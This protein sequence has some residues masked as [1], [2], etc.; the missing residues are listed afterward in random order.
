MKVRFSFLSTA[1]S[2]SLLL[3]L[4]AACSGATDTPQATA[5]PDPTPGQA[6]DPLSADDRMAVE[7]AGQWEAIVLEWDQLHQD[8]DQWRAG[9]TSCHRSSVHEALQG[10]AADF[11]GVTA[12]AGSL[13]RAT[14]TQELADI[15]VAAAEEEEAA[16]RQLRDRWQPDDT[17]LFEQ[18][19]LRRSDA[20][21][22]RRNVED[23][24]LELREQLETAADPRVKAALRDFSEAVD[25]V[26][27]D[28]N[29]FHG[30]YAALK[31]ASVQMDPSALIAQ[32]DQLLTQFDAVVDAVSELPSVD[33]TEGMAEML[34]AAAEA[35]REA[36]IAVHGKLQENLNAPFGVPPP[37]PIGGT[38]SPLGEV[39]AVFEE[40]E[41]RLER[42][43]RT[44][45]L[46]LDDDLKEKLA[47]VENFDVHYGE[48]LVAWDA[49]HQSYRDWRKTDGG[50]DRTEVLQALDGF[51]LRMSELGREVRRL[52]QSS[53]LLPM[54]TLLVE[55]A[56][57]EEGA[58]RA[59]RN[60]W[61]PFTVDAFKVM[62]Q[63]RLN[64]DRLRRQAGIGLQGLSD[65]S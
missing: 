32:L 65:R 52:P 27:D 59:L 38:G 57:R 25:A 46:L 7:F 19:E 53:Y 56:E 14:I 13:P 2:G 8:F 47:E 22:A 64:A 24:S 30:D 45:E 18:V 40:S 55:A 41:A 61:R 36:L 50:C 34:L 9:L 54:Y 60:S 26:S 6:T 16:F 29:G 33:A 5:S 20:A 42:V 37:P 17:A 35:E 43:S 58:V 11:A 28:W 48:L 62:D 15:L 12:Q 21:Q 31:D 4:L 1:L 63:E 49:F 44:I 3:A 23:M 10:F 51:N 39:D